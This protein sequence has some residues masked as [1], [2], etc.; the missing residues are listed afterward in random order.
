M[1]VPDTPTHFPELQRLEI[2]QLRRLLQ[3]SVA[4][5]SHIKLSKEIS[6]LESIKKELIVSNGEQA[7]VLLKQEEL[8]T[9]KRA[10]IAALQCS[11]KDSI[12]DY[13]KK[14]EIYGRKFGMESSQIIANVK[15]NI[16]ELDRKSETVGQDFEKG[17]IELAK[18]L[19]VEK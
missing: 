1:P 7:D 9:T 8:I 17:K 15:K 5:Q 16:E 6:Y 19:Q 14:A 13:N 2:T 11:M 3:D 12:S 18:Y 4:L 10:E